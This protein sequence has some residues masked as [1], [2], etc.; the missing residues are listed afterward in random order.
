M[1]R[2]EAT[3]F[4]KRIP[5]IIS[6]GRIVGTCILPLLMWKS[7]E[8]EIYIPLID[9]TFTNVPL[10]WLI[11]FVILLASDW[12][13]GQLARKL[14]AKSELGA[15]LD[16][17]GDIFLLIVGA[18]SCFVWFVRDNL[19]NWQFWL[20]L[21]IMI[22]AVGNRFLTLV[23]AKIYHN[24]ANMVHTYYQKSFTTCCY[25]AICYWAFL[26]TIPEWSIIF[27][28]CLSIF[29]T[30]DEC[31]YVMRSTKYD[32]DFKGHF[33]EKYEKRTSNKK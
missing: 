30:F 31:I 33:F 6:I 17:Y 27:L 28:I 26:R 32:V 23:F 13:D 1:E 8:K 16:V 7:W 29:A 22:W 5:N 2:P 24:Q 12:L 14:N 9:R 15:A 21:G 18:T 19:E 11:V 4:K 10:I 20:Y 25:V 3:G